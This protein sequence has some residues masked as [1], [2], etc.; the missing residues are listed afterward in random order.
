[1]L[2]LGAGGLAIQMLDILL[3][4]FEE[5]Q[6]TFFD[7][8][9]GDIRPIIRNYNIIR[10]IDEIRSIL[11]KDNRFVPAF[12]GPG[13]RKAL[14]KSILK[15]GGKPAQIFAKSVSIS[16]VSTEI[17]SGT[18]ILN[19]TVVEAGCN[20]GNYVLIN[21]NCSVCHESSIGNYTELGPGTSILGRC[22]IGNNILIGSGSILL[23]GVKIGDNAIIGGGT[24]VNRDLPPNSKAVGVPCRLI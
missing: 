20:I 1:M 5:K 14:V 12:S 19:N 10:N 23:P 2:I 11:E 9:V 8:T 18:V 22:R 21:L 13:N 7:G 3:D 16:K 4:Q 6:L 15:M 17:G 24:V